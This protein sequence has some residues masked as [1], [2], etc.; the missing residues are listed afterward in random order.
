MRGLLE[1]ALE[2]SD[3]LDRGLITDRLAQLGDQL[4]AAGFLVG[5]YPIAQIVEGFFD[6]VGQAVGLVSL[7]HGLPALPVLRGVGFRLPDHALDLALVQVGGA[8]D[9]DPLLFARVPIAG[10]DVQD[11]VGVD[12]EGDLDL[13]YPPRRRPYALEL[14]LPEHPVV[15]GHLPLTL[16]HHD[17]HGALVV[18]GGGEHLGLAGRN[19]RIALDQPGHDPAQGFHPEGQGGDVQEQDVLDV[20]AD[21]S[22]LDRGAHGHHLVGVHGHVGLLAC[23]QLA[24]QLLNGRDAGGSADQNHLVD[25]LLAHLGV[26]Q[27]LPHRS[28][29]ALDELAGQLIELPP[30]HVHVQV[31]GP[32]GVRRNERQVHRGLGG[33]GK[34][35]LGLLRRL[36][37][38]LEGLAVLADVDALVL[39]ELL[40]HPVRERLVEIV[41][42]QVRVAGGGAHLAQPVAYLEDRHVEGAASEVEDHDGFAVLLVHAVR[43]G[44]RGGLVDDAQDLQTGDA[45]GVLGGLALG[46]VEVGGDGDHCLTDPLAQVIRGVIDELAQDLCRNLLRGDLLALDVEAGG[47]VG[48]RL[49]LV[50]DNGDL[51][52]HLAVLPPDETLG[53]VYRRLRVEHRLPLGHLADQPL[54]VLGIGHH[55]RGGACPFAVVDDR[56]L[57]AFEH[58]DTG[59]GGAQIYAYRFCHDSTSLQKSVKINLSPLSDASS[60]PSLK[61]GRL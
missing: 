49:H 13:R 46:V 53:R 52:G 30:G 31:L 33:G 25:V 45:S 6:L 15:P 9:R 10:G 27:G 34:L 55:G 22:R 32:V 48:S 23:G 39:L 28:H 43:Q 4:L 21:D 37:Q 7:F 41:S 24:H 54:A 40:G 35:D 19:G 14:E 59:V 2:P 20:S 36:V 5:W 47:P 16:E 8:A 42:A 50:G 51:G 58:R 12:V 60:V 29:A 26:P 44:R 38:P 18:V 57:V 56:S 17:V 61:E 1:L 11:A 3:L